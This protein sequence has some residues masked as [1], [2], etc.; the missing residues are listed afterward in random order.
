MPGWRSLRI[1]AFWAVLENNGP[2]CPAG[3]MMSSGPGLSRCWVG[4][5]GID[6]AVS[7]S[8][9]VSSRPL[10]TRVLTPVSPQL[11]HG[12]LEINTLGSVSPQLTSGLPG[13][14]FPSILPQQLS[15][16][17]ETVPPA[18]VSP[19]LNPAEALEPR[20][21]RRKARRLGGGGI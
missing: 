14:L 11:C 21:Q 9:H 15:G 1:R 10:E 7:V 3:A 20:G 18:P 5:L 8:R 2:R 19:H 6:R 17:P 4:P 12:L 16:S 13:T